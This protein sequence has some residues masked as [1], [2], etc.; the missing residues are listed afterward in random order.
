[1][2]RVYKIATYGCLGLFGIYLF[3]CSDIVRADAADDVRAISTICAAS[4]GIIAIKTEGIAGE[5]ILVDARWWKEFLVS[6]VNNDEAVALSMIEAVAMQIQDNFDNGIIDWDRFIDVA[7]QCSAA[8]AEIIL[9][10]AKE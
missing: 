2:N 8:K 3:L 4:T 10:A 6:W 9:E 1:M 7:T 5:I